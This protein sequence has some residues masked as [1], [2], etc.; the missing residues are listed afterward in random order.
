MVT[1]FL[2]AKVKLNEAD[3][4]PF[5]FI[6][7]EKRTAELSKVT[8]KIQIIELNFGTYAFCLLTITR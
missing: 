2:E 4:R 8:Y 3:A 7:R 1:Y 5:G 6:L